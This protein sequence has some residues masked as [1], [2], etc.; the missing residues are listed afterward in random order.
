MVD[1]YSQGRY[2]FAALNSGSEDRTLSIDWFVL[3]QMFYSINQPF[4][5]K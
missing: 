5:I 4:D 1:L 3:A 2:N